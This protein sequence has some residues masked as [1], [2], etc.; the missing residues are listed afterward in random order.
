MDANNNGIPDSQEFLFTIVKA[1]VLLW[2]MSMLS[3]SYFTETQI[4]RTFFATTM[5]A[6]AA[7]FGIKKQEQ[8][9]TELPQKAGR[10]ELPSGFDK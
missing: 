5:T 4:D 7:S 8:K 3:V 9:K 6:S 2:S 1:G 10:T